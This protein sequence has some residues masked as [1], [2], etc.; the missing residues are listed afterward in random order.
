MSFQGRSI[1]ILLVVY[2]NY[3]QDKM[4]SPIATYNS[5]IWGTMAFPVKKKNKN[6]IHMDNRKN[7][8]EDLQIKFCKRLLGVSN[9]TTN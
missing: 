5:E 2:H 3:G 6:F 4:I 9:K 1:S 7:P 8:I